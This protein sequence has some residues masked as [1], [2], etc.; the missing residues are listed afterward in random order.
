MRKT[1][2]R[3]GRTAMIAQGLVGLGRLMRMRRLKRGRTEVGW[4]RESVNKV[5]SMFKEDLNNR[6]GI[7]RF[8]EDG[9]G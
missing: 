9:R 5:M 4:S 1:M 6:I 3:K 7:M 8:F 2:R